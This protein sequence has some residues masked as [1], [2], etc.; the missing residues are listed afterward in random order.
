MMTEKQFRPVAFYGKTIFVE[1]GFGFHLDP[2]AKTLMI[3]EK[4]YTDFNAVL[5][6]QDDEDSIRVLPRWQ[7]NFVFKADGIYVIRERFDGD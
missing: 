5:I 7:T 4:D 1:E 6:Y 2:E 3:M